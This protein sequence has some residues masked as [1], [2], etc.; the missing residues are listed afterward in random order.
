MAWPASVA[1]WADR[2]D[3][4]GLAQGGAERPEQARAVARAHLEHA[5]GLAGVRRPPRRGP[6]RARAGRGPRAGGPA[7]ARRGR[8]RPRRSSCWVRKAAS[9]TSATRSLSTRQ[10]FTATPSTVCSTAARTWTPAEA[11]SPA[12]S[13]NSPSRSGAAIS[14]S[15]PPGPGLDADPGPPVEGDRAGQAEVDEPGEVDRVVVRPAVDEHP[16]DLVGERADQRGP[17]RRPGRRAGRAGVGLGEA[18]QQREHVAAALD[19]GDQRVLRLGVGVVAPGRQLGQRQVL[20]DQQGDE[21]GVLAAQP[22]P[23]DRRPGDRARPTAGCCGAGTGQ[24]ADVVQQGGEQQQV[25][26]VDLGEVAVRL[27]HGLHGVPVDGV[28]VHRVVLRPGA[29]AASTP[30][31]SR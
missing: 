26:P 12:V 19:R 20:A 3:R 7:R 23:V 11:S 13:L 31:A 15:T 18:P 2:M 21:V 10:V 29:D 27:D 22:D 16:L 14:S 24:L 9:G 28:P 8:R 17:P 30:A 4:P 5:R 25:R 1:T 6:A